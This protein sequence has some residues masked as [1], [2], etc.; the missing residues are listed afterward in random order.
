VRVWDTT[1]FKCLYHIHSSQDVGDVF[2]VVFS[3]AL[4]TMYI[5][6]QNT[7]IQVANNRDSV[8][9]FAVVCYIPLTLLLIFSGS[10]FQSPNQTCLIR[11]IS[12][13]VSVATCLGSLRDRLRPMS[14]KIIK[15][16]DTAFQSR[17]SIKTV[18]LDTYIA[19]FLERSPMSKARSCFRDLER[20]TS[21]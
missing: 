4:N 6:C 18:I 14:P 9:R 19:S 7:S 11:P 16:F 17:A 13:T 3:D 10:I 15:S 8:V 1:T 12:P 20:V 21:R 5:G 2:S